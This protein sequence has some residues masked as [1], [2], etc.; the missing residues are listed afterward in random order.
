M[1]NYTLKEIFV[2]GLELGYDSLY[3][4]ELRKQIEVYLSNN[5]E[6]S[7]DPL[8]ERG[9]TPFEDDPWDESRV[10]TDTEFEYND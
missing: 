7:L 5:D 10:N 2:M 9:T 1:E 6:A 3:D 8:W 4:S